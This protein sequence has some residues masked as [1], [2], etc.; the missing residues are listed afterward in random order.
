MSIPAT[1]TAIFHRSTGSVDNLVSIDDFMAQAV[2]FFPDRNPQE[3]RCDMI[4]RLY[5]EEYFTL[6]PAEGWR[7][8]PANYLEKAGVRFHYLKRRRS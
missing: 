6:V 2:K 4:G 8:P 1:M 7:K 5:T 3:V